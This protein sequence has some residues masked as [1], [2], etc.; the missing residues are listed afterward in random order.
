MCCGVLHVQA[1]AKLD[2]AALLRLA[3]ALSVQF[4]SAQAAVAAIP[5]APVTSC[6]LAVEPVS[7]PDVFSVAGVAGLVSTLAVVRIA[8]VG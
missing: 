1:V 7:G 3:Q 4:A 8:K 2:D 6:Y 5:E